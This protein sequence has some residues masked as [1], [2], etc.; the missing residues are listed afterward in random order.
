[1]EELYESLKA[2]DEHKPA[3]VDK[4]WVDTRAND[5]VCIF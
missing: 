3:P 5:L 4:M 1:M 2:T